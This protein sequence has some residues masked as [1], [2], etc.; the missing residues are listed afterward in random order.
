MARS[1][2]SKAVLRKEVILSTANS[3]IP[4]VVALTQRKE[5]HHPTARI[6]DYQSNQPCPV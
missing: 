1:R 3:K 6:I 2:A 4:M 5:P